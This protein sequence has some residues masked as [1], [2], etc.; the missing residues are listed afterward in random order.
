MARPSWSSP[1]AATQIDAAEQ[2]R[3]LSSYVN[4]GILTRNEARIKL[5]ET[6]VTDPAANLLMVTTGA[7]PAP[8]DLGLDDP[9]GIK[10]N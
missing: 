4:A 6:P 2:A 9:E 8:L 7:G 10:G 5:G 1:G 3:V